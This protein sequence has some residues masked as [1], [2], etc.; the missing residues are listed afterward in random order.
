MSMTTLGPLNNRTTL[1]YFV[2]ESDHGILPKTLGPAATDVPIDTLFVDDTNLDQ[3]SYS[4]VGWSTQGWVENFNNSLHLSDS[5]SSQVTFKFN[6]TAVWY[7]AS[8]G[9]DRGKLNVTLDGKQSWTVNANS[10]VTVQQKLLWS[11]PNVED[12]EHTLALT[13]VDS[14]GSYMGLDFFRTPPEK[15][16]PAVGPIVGGVVGGLAC[17]VFICLGVLFYVRRYKSQEGREYSARARPAPLPLLNSGQPSRGSAAEPYMTQPV[18][19]LN[20]P[21]AANLPIRRKGLVNTPPLNPHIESSAGTSYI[22]GP[23]ER[24]WPEGAYEGSLPPAYQPAY[25]RTSP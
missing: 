5:T 3:L 6:G 13:H 12:G 25:R 2:I 8:Q 19:G 20:S 24:T 23:S 1:D 9:A 15:H 4:D 14:L 16:K 11:S 10:P 17:L 21:R 7:F 18:D 22:T